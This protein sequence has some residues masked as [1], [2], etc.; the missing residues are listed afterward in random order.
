M[1]TLGT[2]LILILSLGAFVCA[3][4]STGGRVV[5]PARNTSHARVVNCKIVGGSIQVKTHTGT[6]VIVEATGPQISPHARKG[7]APP[8]GM[9]RLDVPVRGLEVTEEDNVIT[10]SSHIS[11]HPNIVITVPVDTSLVLRNANGRIEVNGV[12]GDVSATTLGG[13]LDLEHISGAVT[14]DSLNGPIKVTLDR[15]DPSKP[16]AFTSLNAPIDVTF[17]SSFKA[18]LTVRTERGPVYSDFDVTL[19]RRNVAEK[20]NSPDGQFRI[21]IDRTIVGSINGGGP[22]TTF[23][24]LNGGIYIRK[25]K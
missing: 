12:H 1:K 3:Q 10:V 24:T 15:V 13:H 8:P 4:D 14:A 20:N 16:Q 21:R 6:D 2:S 25:Q 7:P 9:K 17:P 18:N 19:G 11:P 22:E 5:V 23:R